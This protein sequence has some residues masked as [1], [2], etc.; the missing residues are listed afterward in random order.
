MASSSGRSSAGR[1]KSYDEL[2]MQNLGYTYEEDEYGYVDPKTKRISQALISQL[3]SHQ[4]DQL[5]KEDSV[6]RD[7]SSGLRRRDST[8]RTLQLKNATL[9]A[10]RANLDV[11]KI[12]EILNLIPDQTEREKVNTLRE[13]HQSLTIK[14]QV[15]E[16]L[17]AEYREKEASQILDRL[18]RFKLRLSM[19]WHKFVY[20]VKNLSYL[21]SVWHSP[22]KNIQGQFGSGVASYFIFVRW[23]LYIN[24]CN[25]F[26]LL[27]FV[28]IPQFIYE[29]SEAGIHNI[30]V[31]FSPEDLLTGSGWMT[32]STFYFGHYTSSTISVLPGL[33][34]SMPLAYLFIIGVNSLINLLAVS[35][36]L[37][38]AYQKNYVD[39]S[40]EMKNVF[41]NKI[42]SAWDYGIETEDAARLRKRAFCNEIKELLYMQVHNQKE[43]NTVEKIVQ[44]ALMIF[45]NIFIVT[46]TVAVCYLI[47]Y[48]L[49]KKALKVSIKVLEDMTLALT[50][51]LVSSA[52]YFLLN[53][54]TKLEFYFQRKTKLYLTMIRV[55]ILR[56][57]MLG[58]IVYFWMVIYSPSRKENICYETEL[59]KEIYRL[60]I[61]NFLVAVIL[62]TIFGEC[63]RKLLCVYIFPSIKLPKFDVAYNTLDLIYCQTLAWI[64]AFCIPLAP[65]L[66]I[67]M[68]ILLFYIKTLSV[69]YNCTPPKRLWS[70][71]EAQTFYL[72]LTFLMFLFSAFT[73]GYVIF[74][75]DPSMCGPFKDYDKTGDLIRNIFFKKGEEYLASEIIKYLSSP[76][77]MFAVF[78]ALC[79]VV[80]YMRAQAKAHISVVKKIREQLIMEGKDKAFLLRLFDEAFSEEML[81]KNVNLGQKVLMRTYR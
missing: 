59:G 39:T 45:V 76:G 71:N 6:E 7:G 49:E 66:I 55:M 5:F 10:R 28:L 62:F 41:C 44:A 9:G 26:L 25:F 67:V 36:S 40:G 19:A 54:A 57:V 4:I 35:Y 38:N 20:E 32:N 56:T 27:L 21:F 24:L 78:C 72:T 23:L 51:T 22:I 69:T 3:P 64:G 1:S 61:V 42:F 43:K 31:P 29:S 77:V 65:V 68:L 75:I 70:V 74:A 8:Y 33:H 34:Y 2:P 58:I 81:R 11:E 80:Y 14:R 13:M 79:V 48:L 73:V 52:F 16:K 47:Y 37:T 15:K 46:V 50:V 12:Y 63:I 60:I 17:D 53:Y 18:T 30:S